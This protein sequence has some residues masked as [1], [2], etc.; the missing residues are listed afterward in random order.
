MRRFG[1]TATLTPLL[2]AAVFLILAA[3]PA[4]AG[5]TGPASPDS[6]SREMEGKLEGT[7]EGSLAGRLRLILRLSKASDGTVKAVLDSPDQGATGLPVDTV[8][9]KDSS[10]YFEMKNIKAVYRGWVSLDG[11]EIDGQWVQGLNPIPL[12]LRRAGRERAAR[13]FARGRVQ[14]KPCA[15]SLL[16][17]AAG[18][19]TY[20][21]FEDRS[22]RA[23]RKIALN[24]VVIPAI[25][26]NPAPDPIF[27]LSG[28]PG[29][30]AATTVASAGNLLSEL[31][32]DRELVFVDQRGTGASAP[33]R[34]DFFGDKDDMQPY[35]GEALPI[36]K[37]RECRAKLE[38]EANLALYTTPIATD[39]LDEVRSALGYGRINVYGGSY[40]ST[41]ALAYVRQH[42][43][44]TRSAA[45][46]GVA[47][48]DFKLPLPMAKGIQHSLG[49]L[50]DDCAKDETCRAAYPN[51]RAEFET[52]LARLDKAPAVFET[53]NP[54]TRKTERLTLTR[55]AYMD[56]L[57]FMLYRVDVG[58]QL[59]LLIHDTFREDFSRFAAVAF[60]LNRET[61]AAIARGMHLSVV[62]AE[63]VPFITEEMIERETA[64][65]YYGAYRIKSYMKAC[66]EWPRG[67]VPADFL[68]PIKSDVPVLMISGD[69][70]PVTPPWLA[71]AA[72]RHLPNGRQVVIRDAS[73]SSLSDCARGLISEFF[74]KGTAKGLDASCTEGIR[75]PPFVVLPGGAR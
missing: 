9:F 42:G 63:D 36:E 24:I 53:V 2:A 58:S 27:Y 69:L 17:G 22:A 29:A 37:V 8:V 72:V 25:S 48:V 5:Q 21:V 35:V 74:S 41:A 65:T 60:L 6:A 61:E 73:H 30:G 71:E 39:D 55:N 15:S 33:L 62:C 20:E 66:A 16:T 31:R 64:G 12:L 38:K 40:G 18:C 45:V 52:V 56:D 59:P 49:R 10:F 75:R 3:T 54:L 1:L 7:W 28:G 47:P 46:L 13:P 43:G 26:D 11:S 57:R 44:R 68:N 23:G 32:R 67:K 50:F 14:L 70:D 34:C 51:L 4:S 19:G